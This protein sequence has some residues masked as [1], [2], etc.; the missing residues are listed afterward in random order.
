GRRRRHGRGG[1]R[2]AP[3]RGLHDRRHEWGV[4]LLRPGA[5]VDGA[6]RD[7]VHRRRP[8]RSARSAGER[9]RGHAAHT[10]RTARAAAA[11]A[12]RAARPP[13][14]GAG[15]TLWSGRVES[16]LAPEVWLFLKADDW[17]LLPYDIA[18]TRTH[19][20]RL[21]AAG[22]LTDDELAEVSERL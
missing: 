14:A 8:H 2:A 11:R 18:A 16:G 21:H 6:Q 22:L 1:G 9:H 19:A 5:A 10:L 3:R 12:G 17:E 4:A 20:G 15:V 13:G 7:G